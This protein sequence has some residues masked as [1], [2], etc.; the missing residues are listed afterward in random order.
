MATLTFAEMKKLNES[1]GQ[2]WFSEGAAEFF[3]TE[4]ETRHASEGFFITSEHNGDGIR[5]FS[6]RSFD[7]KT[8]KVK[9][10]GRFMEFETLKD[11]RKRLNK[12][13]RIYR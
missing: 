9:T 5:R 12:I 7:L 10:I 8:Y 2:D 6:I 1:I 4:Y 3:N 11:A 13:L